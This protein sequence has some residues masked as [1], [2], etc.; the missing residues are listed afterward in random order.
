MHRITRIIYIIVFS[1]AFVYLSAAPACALSIAVHVPEKYTDIEAGERFYFEIEVK[2]PENPSRKDLRFNYEIKKDGRVIAQSKVLK[3]IET[4]TSFI[5]FIVIPE[6]AKAG[7]HIIDVTVSD[8][9]N[10][11][12]N[13]SASFQVMG[14]IGDQVKLYLFILLGII[15]FVGL[16]AGVQ[17][18]VMKKI[19][20]RRS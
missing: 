1:L 7:L 2:Y 3:A 13:V 16:S 5:D 15:L 6:M 4:Q 17:I 12:E 20:K 8:Y 19:K 9:K 14:G 10:L 11:R 18:F